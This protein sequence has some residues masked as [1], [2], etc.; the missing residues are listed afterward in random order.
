MEETVEQELQTQVVQVV[1]VQQEVRV[2]Q[3]LEEE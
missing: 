2:V 3:C 1:L